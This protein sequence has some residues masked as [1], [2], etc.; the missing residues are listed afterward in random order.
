MRS[1]RAKILFS[2]R[3]P[4]DLCKIELAMVGRTRARG[5]REGMHEPQSSGP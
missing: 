2:H 3:N 4:G 5:K 1:D